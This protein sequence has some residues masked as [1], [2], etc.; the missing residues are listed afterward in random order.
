[1]AEFTATEV[2]S[3]ATHNITFERVVGKDK[4]SFPTTI[5]F[6]KDGENL[7]MR[8]VTPFSACFVKQLNFSSYVRG[9]IDIFTAKPVLRIELKDLES[10]E[11]LEPSGRARLT[12]GQFKV[13]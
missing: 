5:Y 11:V 8:L 10:K 9:S 12:F 4:P 1:M 3:N 2:F 6:P 7:L 13:N